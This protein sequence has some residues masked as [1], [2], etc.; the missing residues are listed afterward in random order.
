MFSVLG[1]CVKNTNIFY[2]KYITLSGYVFSGVDQITIESHDV[3]FIQ[4][5]LLQHWSYNLSRTMDSHCNFSWGKS[6][7]I[8]HTPDKLAM[9]RRWNDLEAWKYIIH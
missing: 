4:Q 7:L 1:L 8:K 2:C 6:L 9:I 3:D 5:C